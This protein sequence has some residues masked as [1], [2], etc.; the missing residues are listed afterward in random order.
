MLG[1]LAVGDKKNLIGGKRDVG[2]GHTVAHLCNAA[3]ADDGDGW[4]RLP[5]EI[6]EHNLRDGKPGFLCQA[7]HSLEASR[8]FRQAIETQ[9]ARVHLMQGAVGHAMEKPISL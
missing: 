3:A 2:S 8:G 6:A 9:E 4:E 5:A 7:L 1:L